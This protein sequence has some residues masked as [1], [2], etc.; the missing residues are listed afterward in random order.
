M[1]VRMYVCICVGMYL[2]IFI[3]TVLMNFSE[4][5]K[6]PLQR[7]D[8]RVVVYTRPRCY[9]HCTLPVP[10][11]ELGPVRRAHPHDL[12]HSFLGLG[13]RWTSLPVECPKAL[14]EQCLRMLRHRGLRSGYCRVSVSWPP[15]EEV[16][17]VLVVVYYR[18][19]T[20]FPRI[21]REVRD[22]RG[23]CRGQREAESSNAAVH[24]EKTGGGLPL[25]PLLGRPG[26]KAARRSPLR[27]CPWT[28][29]SSVVSSSL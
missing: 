20:P 19:P 24:R 27:S 6:L 16:N 18:Y 4:K 11:P 9:N 1:Y 5:V 14:H 23:P 13:Q 2:D 7:F 25:E 28:A 26:L 17:D 8:H 22:R 12:W 21:D 29:F 10:P 3:A 15:H